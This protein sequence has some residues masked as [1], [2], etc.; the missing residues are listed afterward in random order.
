M[1]RFTIEC[2]YRIVRNTENHKPHHHHAA[3]GTTLRSKDGPIV[4]KP[5]QPQAASSSETAAPVEVPSLVE[6]GDINTGVD[7]GSNLFSEC[8]CDLSAEAMQRAFAPALAVAPGRKRGQRPGGVKVKQEV[9][10]P[11][12]KKARKKQSADPVISHIASATVHEQSQSS[13]SVSMER[14][15]DFTRWINT[16]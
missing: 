8:D 16:R 3:G 11:V 15:M 6:A 2:A 7:S 14:L 13:V 4:P 5:P 10:G 9:E 1:H 12:A